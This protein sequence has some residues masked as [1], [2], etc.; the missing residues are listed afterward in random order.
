MSRL[1]S[2]IQNEIIKT[3][4]YTP[5]QVYGMSYIETIAAYHHTPFYHKTLKNK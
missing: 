4:L 3:G 5:E 1:F 2:H